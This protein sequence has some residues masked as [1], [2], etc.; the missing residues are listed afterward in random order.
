MTSLD[1]LDMHF[2]IFDIVHQY[3]SSVSLFNLHFVEGR[4]LS[5]LSFAIW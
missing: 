4:S 1:L 3:C 2:I 5:L